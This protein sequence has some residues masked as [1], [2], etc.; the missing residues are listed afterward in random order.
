MCVYD[1]AWQTFNLTELCYGST[2]FSVKDSNGCK[3]K[4]NVRLA[5]PAWCLESN[6]SVSSSSRDYWTLPEGMLPWLIAVCALVVAFVIVGIVACCLWSC[7]SEHTPSEPKEKDLEKAENST[8]ALVA[9]GNDEDDNFDDNPAS[10]KE[11]PKP[12]P[13]S[14][15]KDSDKDSDKE[16]DVPHSDKESEKEEHP[17]EPEKKK[18]K[19]KK[20]RSPKVMDEAAA[21]EVELTEM[22]QERLLSTDDDHKEPDE[23]KAKKRK[24]VHHHNKHTKVEEEDTGEASMEESA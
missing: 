16:S 2:D 15:E 19:K 3:I 7:V 17:T 22:G 4:F 13:G 23:Q 8:T 5:V 11:S 14:S 9:K 1:A 10:P 20:K 24:R 18:K 21:G 6:E 12:S